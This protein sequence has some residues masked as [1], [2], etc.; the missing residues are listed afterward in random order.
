MHSTDGC[1]LRSPKRL[2]VFLLVLAS[3]AAASGSASAA[4]RPGGLSS[5]G[6]ARIAPALATELASVEADEAVSAIVV[7]RAKAHLSTIPRSSRAARLRAVVTG[8]H[9]LAE[10]TQR[11]LRALVAARRAEGKV[12]RAR[13]LWVFNG[14]AITATPDVIL[15][16][17][18]R[19]EVLSVRPDATIRA[20]RRLAAAAPPEPNI[21]LVNAPALWALGFRG[22][23]VVVASMDTG[24]DIDH[25]EL[26][27][28]WRGGTNSWYD[29]NGQHPAEPTDVNG[30]GTWTMGVMVGRDLGG[31][32]IGM[33]PEATWVAVK[34]FNDNGVASVSGIHLGF[35]WLL[36]P[37]GDPTTPDAPHVVNNSWTFGSPGC[38]LEFQL[39]LQTLRAAGI[40]PVFAAGNSGPGAAT[41]MS[42]ANNPEALAVGAT[43]NAD[44]LWPSSSRGPSACAGPTTFPDLVAPGASVRTSDLFGL[45]TQQSGTSLAAPHVAGALALL[46]DAF[47]NLTSDQ[48]EA[49]L[50]ETALDLGAS[51]PD[52]D[53]GYGRLDVLAAYESVP[54]PNT[55]PVVDAG[56]DQ[57]ITLP[58][59]ASL[60]GTVTDDGLPSGSLTTLWTAQAGPGAVTFGDA[61]AVDTSAAFSAPGTYI[62]RLTANDGALSTFDDLTIAVNPTPSIFADGFESADTS[63]WSAEIDA[64]SDLTVTQGAAL[65]GA[66]GLRALIDNG[67]SMYVRDDSPS[68]ETAYSAQFLFD[69]NGVRMSGGDTHRILVARG[70]QVD[71]VRVDFRRTKAGSYQLSA[72]VRTDAGSYPATSWFTISDAPHRVEVV[73]LAATGVGMR[74]GSMSFRLDGAPKQILAGLDTDLLRVEQ[75]RLGPLQGIDARTRGAEFFDDFVSRR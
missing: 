49:A 56:Q 15:E 11:G 17:A 7:L 31:S 18:A 12:V 66:R 57:T 13:W 27:S 3:A 23:G 9:D 10:Q 70:N 53:F 22:Q 47:P 74:D 72:S 69:A 33:A 26:A 52:S 45:Y 5:S 16:L 32:A 24:V 1:A 19:P 41:S 68:A 38:N 30:H 55:P 48:Q 25:P 67:T 35:Q 51:G 75:A 59:A 46:L 21:A 2:V 4:L 29:P 36:D 40:V 28:Q 14:L 50:E 64:E 6:A 8:L 62:L 20:P 34:I 39:D 42:P 63:A 73:W 43:S 61:G 54:P 44:L 58:A 60:D 37:D 71:L 65:A